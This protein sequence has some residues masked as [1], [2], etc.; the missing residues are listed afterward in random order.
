MLA[1]SGY[2]VEDVFRRMK[3]KHFVVELKFDGERML[4]SRMGTITCCCGMGYITTVQC[5]SR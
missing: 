3:G 5:H 4:V 1:N 2:G